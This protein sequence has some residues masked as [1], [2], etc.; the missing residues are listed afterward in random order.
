MRK[1]MN[2]FSVIS[3]SFINILIIS[4]FVYAES[5]SF[6]NT[7]SEQISNYDNKIDIS[8]FN[9]YLIENGFKERYAKLLENETISEDGRYYDYSGL[10]NSPCA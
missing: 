10:S 1:L 9:G 7:N 4:Q 5:G 3:L 6:N 8:G 2:I